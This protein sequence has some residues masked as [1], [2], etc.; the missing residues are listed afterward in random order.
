M[1]ED[2]LLESYDYDLP[3]ELIAQRPAA[4]PGSSRLL[5]MQRENGRGA[6]CR[7]AMFSDLPDLL[8]KD[9][10]LVANNA[11]VLPCRIKWTRPGGGRAEFLL[12]TPLPLL[13]AS[14]C[15]ESGG[16]FSARAEALLKP[17]AKFK[18]GQAFAVRGDLECAIIQKRD[19]GR[20]DVLLRW[21]GS[22][23]E[24]FN[25]CGSLP[26][27]PYIKREAESADQERY[28]TIYA[29]KTGAAAAPT[30]GLH[31]TPEIRRALEEK[32]FLWR[33]ITLYTGYGTFSPVRSADILKHKM[34]AEFVE[35]DS[36][37]ADAINTAIK[38]GRPV[39]AVGT[40]SM[41]ALEGA[42]R[43]AGGMRP[44]SGW[45]D[46]FIYPGHEFKTAS[47]LITNFHLPKSSLLMLASAF[48]GRKETLSAY[49]HAVRS[50]YRFFSYGDAMLIV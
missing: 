23:E 25:K 35:I 36:G 5:F 48:A 46:I 22:L 15:A 37:A 9:A 27:P 2:Y 43:V 31:F 12:L 26:L 17:G 29:S 4:A 44:F 28:Q 30:A 50:G 49:R 32:G 40:T 45:T 16:F 19:Y 24:I 6:A 10:L 11:R 20:H 38:D 7:D 3:E 47:G 39:I 18:A 21:R 14:A 33:E 34:H 13:L 42:A 8:P 1:S 41:R